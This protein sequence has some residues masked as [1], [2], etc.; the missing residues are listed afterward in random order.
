MKMTRMTG[1]PVTEM[2]NKPGTDVN[3]GVM[4]KAGLIE[5][6]GLHEC[7]SCGYRWSYVCDLDFDED[8][9]VSCCPV[10]KGLIENGGEG[11]VPCSFR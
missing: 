8:E 6:N 3:E 1:G 11:E 5:T 2:I 7:P 10:C 9:R 4:F